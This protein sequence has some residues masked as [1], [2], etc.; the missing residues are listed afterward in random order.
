MQKEARK[1]FW[2]VADWVC[3][4]A[5][6]T[7]R[8]PI[9]LCENMDSLRFDANWSIWT[10]SYGE[11]LSLSS[12]WSMSKC[13]KLNLLIFEAY[14]N[15]FSMLAITILVKIWYKWNWTNRTMSHDQYCWHWKK[16][17]SS[18]D[19]L[20]CFHNYRILVAEKEIKRRR[21]IPNPGLRVRF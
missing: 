2:C 9:S 5:S 1:T 15:I 16:H 6:F 3:L 10:V 8:K 14:Q 19:Y 7:L 11:T 20:F 13:Q 18:Q 12:Y 21:R 4:F 17:T